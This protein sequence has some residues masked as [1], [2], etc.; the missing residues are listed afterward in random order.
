[1]TITVRRK[2][3]EKRLNMKA[4]K[5]EKDNKKHVNIANI[6]QFVDLIRDRKTI[7]III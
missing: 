1:M 7:H 2:N 4:K 6:K 5:E 3:T